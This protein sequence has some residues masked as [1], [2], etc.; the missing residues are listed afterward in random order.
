MINQNIDMIVLDSIF[1]KNLKGLYLVPRAR[2]EL[3]RQCN[4]TQDFKSCA[5]TSSATQAHQL[6]V[7]LTFA[8]KFR[9]FQVLS[10]QK[11]VSTSQ[12]AA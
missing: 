6:K 12:H 8:L 11:F 9:F 3:A 5:S 1:L 4:P 2:I 10:M 7:D